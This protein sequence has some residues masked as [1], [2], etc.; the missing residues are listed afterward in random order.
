MRYKYP[1]TLYLPFSP[2][3]AKGDDVVNT[4]QFTGKDIV[5]T[6]KMDGENTTMYR[7]GIHARSIDS[8][9]HYSRNWVKN[10]HS[11]VCHKIPVGWRVCGENLF[12]V[13]SIA[14]KNLPSYFMLFSVWNANNICL[15]WDDTVEFANTNGFD[16]VPVLYEGIYNT[17]KLLSLYTPSYNGD[18]C[19][20]YVVRLRDAFRYNNF[21]KS[22]AK[23]VRESH[24]QTDK[25]WMHTKIVK[26]ITQGG[27][28]VHQ[29]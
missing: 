22:T 28:A 25:H 29:L 13:H 9:N 2:S 20:G 6:V 18:T 15:S 3:I 12:A 10:F 27:V 19:E 17:N 26:N 8:K 4:D 23:Y 11:Q 1:K 14:Y 7:D 5:V 24:V 21:S 16:L